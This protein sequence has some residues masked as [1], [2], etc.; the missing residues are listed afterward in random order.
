MLKGGNVDGIWMGICGIGSVD[1]IGN[2]IP[3]RPGIEG[4]G[5]DAS[6]AAVAAPPSVRGF[7]G[8][9]VGVVA[10]PGGAVGVGC[11]GVPIGGSAVGVAGV[12]AAVGCATGGVAVAVGFAVGSFIEGRSNSPLASATATMPIAITLI[13]MSNQTE[14]RRGPLVV[15]PG[16]VGRFA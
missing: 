5:A 6:S 7:A 12:G 15:C 4:G 11:T 8:V 2:G 13:P 1:G 9:F 3:G 10:G 16:T 14:R